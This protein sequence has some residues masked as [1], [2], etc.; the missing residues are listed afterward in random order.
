MCKAKALAIERLP[1]EEMPKR[2]AQLMEIWAERTDF[3]DPA[4]EIEA[5]N[6]VR[7]DFTSQ[8]CALQGFHYTCPNCFC[9]LDGL[10]M[11]GLISVHR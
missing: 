3:R 2:I 11:R 6:V 10:R 5:I 4:H 9:W 8:G 1:T 7:K